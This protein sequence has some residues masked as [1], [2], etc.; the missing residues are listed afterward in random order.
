MLKYI[1]TDLAKSCWSWDC[2]R[3][4]RIECHICVNSC[5]HQATRMNG[6]SV[7][8]RAPWGS[9]AITRFPSPRT[10]RPDIRTGVNLIYKWNR[11][12][13]FLWRE[14]FI[15]EKGLRAGS[16]PVTP[17]EPSKWDAAPENLDVPTTLDLQL[18]GRKELIS[19]LG[20][21]SS[22]TEATWITQG[23]LTCSCGGQKSKMGLTALRPR[24]CHSYVLSRGGGL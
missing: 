11:R 21:K 19:K 22:F 17:Y 16:Y 2:R 7:G 8:Y 24:C 6:H 12:Q 10:R 9:R 23:S 18:I 15:S 3:C 5:R 13:S 14:A 4:V 20:Y 1:I